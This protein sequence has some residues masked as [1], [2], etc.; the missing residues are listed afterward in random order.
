MLLT[1]LL[2]LDI[3]L[4][5][6]VPNSGQETTGRWCPGREGAIASKAEIL[7]RQAR[8]VPSELQ[9]LAPYPQ[10]DYLHGHPG[11]LLL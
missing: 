4:P 1:W 10:G 11:S 6:S 8:L 3:Y 2:S 7:C 9:A 5:I